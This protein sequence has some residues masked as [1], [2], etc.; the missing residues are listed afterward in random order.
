MADLQEERDQGID[1]NELVSNLNIDCT[2]P[3][4]SQVETC[5]DPE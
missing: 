1:A 2:A 5:P 3:I 4:L